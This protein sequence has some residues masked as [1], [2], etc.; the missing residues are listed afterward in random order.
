MLATIFLCFNESCVEHEDIEQRLDR[1][2]IMLIVKFRDQ[3]LDEEKPLINTDYILNQKLYIAPLVTK[4][5]LSRRMMLLLVV[6]LMIGGY[7]DVMYSTTII[8]VVSQLILLTSII[9]YVITTPFI[10]TSGGQPYVFELLSDIKENNRVDIRLYFTR[11]YCEF[12]A[13]ASVS[14]TMDDQRTVLTL[15][16]IKDMVVS[17]KNDLMNSGLIKEIQIPFED[18]SRDLYKALTYREST[19]V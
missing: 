5:S 18:E 10:G 9:Y 7:I 15:G 6:Y 1:R 13:V 16:N 14:R 8:G 3:M 19:E 17:D 12:N 11:Y 2:V 4:S